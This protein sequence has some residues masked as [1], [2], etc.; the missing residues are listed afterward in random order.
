MVLTRPAVKIHEHLRWLTK[1]EYLSDSCVC[2]SPLEGFL[3]M[4]ISVR[5]HT[6]GSES[7]QNK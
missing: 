6:V 3:L 1:F 4:C 7:Q 2:Y 5:I